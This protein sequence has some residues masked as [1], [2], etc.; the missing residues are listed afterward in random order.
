MNTDQ[1]QGTQHEL[2]HERRGRA[3][4]GTESQIRGT[5][6]HQHR[7]DSLFR[8]AGAV[9]KHDT[10][11]AHHHKQQQ[12]QPQA[13]RVPPRSHAVPP[14]SFGLRRPAKAPKLSICATSSSNVPLTITD[15]QHYPHLVSPAKSSPSDMSY[16]P[17]SRLASRVSRSWRPAIRTPLGAQ[18]G[19]LRLAS[20]SSN[21][22]TCGLR[23]EWL[24]RRWTPRHPQQHRCAE[25]R[26]RGRGSAIPR[27]GRIGMPT[28]AWLVLADEASSRCPNKRSERPMPITVTGA[29]LARACMQLLPG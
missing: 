10:K 19:D 26:R 3:G 28:V 22:A 12:C 11:P 29:A 17:S 15:G 25:A 5:R 23:V 13:A 24:R 18:S 4:R 1:R 7:S 8:C 2:R 21:P 6:V 27:T 20:A 14:S 9:L 16:L